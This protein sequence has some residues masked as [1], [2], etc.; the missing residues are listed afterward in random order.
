MSSVKFAAG[1][2]ALAL[3][4]LF[5][6]LYLPLIQQ[7]LKA[8]EKPVID[9]GFSSFALGVAGSVAGVVAV[10][11]GVPA[12]GK[13]LGQRLINVGE[14][15][16]IKTVVG[17]AYFAVFVGVTGWAAYTWASKQAIAPEVITSEVTVAVGVAV[18][19]VVKLMSET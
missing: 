16:P 14:P 12:P 7:T 5:V 10:W 6:V 13:L 11:F 4:A 19:A 8:T 9:A 2:V 15:S 3:A 17:W 18:A 1:F